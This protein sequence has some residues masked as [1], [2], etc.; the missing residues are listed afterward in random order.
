MRLP[1]ELTCVKTILFK[2]AAWQLLEAA[3]LPLVIAQAPLTRFAA[4]RFACVSRDITLQV[5]PVL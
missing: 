4:L 2:V 1:T 5:P 3:A